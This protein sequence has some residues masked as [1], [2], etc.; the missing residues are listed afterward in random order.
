MI[1][2]LAKEAPKDLLALQYAAWVCENACAMPATKSNTVVV[3]EA[4]RSIARSKFRAEKWQHPDY[5]AFLWL[6]RKIDFAQME[7]RAINHLFFLN[8]EYNDVSEPD[9]KLPEF[10]ACPS[11]VNGWLTVEHADK[12]RV[13]RCDCWMKWR[14]GL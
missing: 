14:A 11:C 3:S 13:R 1:C 7:K 2:D 5:T 12:R 6:V 10:E 4:I 9:K 8:G